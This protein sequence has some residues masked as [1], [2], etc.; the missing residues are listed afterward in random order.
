V[1]PGADGLDRVHDQRLQFDHDV[2]GALAF[3]GFEEQAGDPR[4]VHG[5]GRVR[6]IAGESLMGVVIA[7]LMIRGILGITEVS[8]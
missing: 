2:I 7:L 6:I 5:A 1:D 3:S 4:G 8:A